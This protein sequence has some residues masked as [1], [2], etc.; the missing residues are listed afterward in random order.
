MRV[1]KFRMEESRVDELKNIN[2]RSGENF[3]AV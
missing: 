1:M 3:V 2:L